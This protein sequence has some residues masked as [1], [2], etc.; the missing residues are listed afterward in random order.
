[1]GMEGLTPE[2]LGM[3]KKDAPEFDLESI[4]LSPEVKG[5][6]DRVNAQYPNMATEAIVATRDIKAGE[7]FKQSIKDDPEAIKVW[8]SLN[9]FLDEN[10]VGMETWLHTKMENHFDKSEGNEDD[11]GSEIEAVNAR[12]NAEIPYLRSVFAKEPLLI[13]DLLLKVKGETIEV[14]AGLPSE[15]KLQEI[16]ERGLNLALERIRSQKDS[17]EKARQVLKRIQGMK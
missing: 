9:S 4:V 15:E 7:L 3:K 1:M 17:E 11:G 8:D 5:V 14:N 13:E 6:L 16:E 2:R 10:A 12:I